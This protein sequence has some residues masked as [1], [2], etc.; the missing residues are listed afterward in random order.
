MDLQLT[1]KIAI[2]TGGT[3]G[4][5]AGIA[6]V[7]A[8]EGVHLALAYRSDTEGALSF[9]RE[10]TEQYGIQA[11]AIKADVTIP[12]EVEAFYQKAL[13]LFPTV[14]ILINNAAGGTPEN[15]PMEELSFDQ[16]QA[17]MN[18]CLSH[19]FT[20]SQAFVRECKSPPMA[21]ISSM[22][23]QKQPSTA[24]VTIKYHTPRPRALSQP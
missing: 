10:L 6:R 1:D 5:G 16:W 22:F 8:A 15:T 20:M 7:L 2:I 24:P 3:R 23:P 21:D 13:A 18:G 9:T 4:I 17:C 11:H 14:H 12:E 19:V